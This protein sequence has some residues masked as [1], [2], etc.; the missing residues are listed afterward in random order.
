MNINGQWQPLEWRNTA[1]NYVWDTEKAHVSGGAFTLK[2]LAKDMAGN[3][4]TA[5]L[6][7]QV[8]N[9]TWPLITLW[10]LL[11]ALTVTAVF[12]PRRKAWRELTA[13]SSLMVALGLADYF[14]EEE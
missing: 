7:F 3:T 11:L 4:Q 12:D 2:L 13:L 6:K 5:S 14:K 10:A 9:R 1:W 8:L